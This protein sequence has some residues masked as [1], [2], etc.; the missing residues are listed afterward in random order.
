VIF[1]VFDGVVILRIG[2]D[3]DNELLFRRAGN[4]MILRLFISCFWVVDVL[5][6]GLTV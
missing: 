2:W 1:G 4:A 3:L 5:L 6:T